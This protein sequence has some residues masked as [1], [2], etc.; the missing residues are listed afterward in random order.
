MTHAS[1]IG[2]VIEC[3][4]RY[5]LATLNGRKKCVMKLS[6]QAGA[7]GQPLIEASVNGFSY[8]PHAET[9]QGPRHQNGSNNAENTEPVR[10]VPSWCNA[11]VKSCTDVVPY[12]IVIGGKDVKPILSWGKV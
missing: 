3:I 9:V 6:R 2:W 4:S 10:L 8:L 12:S 1:R 11:E 5:H 7:F